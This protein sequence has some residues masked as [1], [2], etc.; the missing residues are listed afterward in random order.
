MNAKSIWARLSHVAAGIALS[1]VASV[2]LADDTDIY[3]NPGAGL[4]AGSE[5]M[6][7]FSL[8]YRPNL[9]STACNGNECDTLIA[10]G[11][12]APA[13]PYTFFD[14]LRAALRKAMEP[15]DGIRVGLM[16]NHENQNNCEGPNSGCSNGGYIAMGFQPFLTGDTNGAKA[17]FHAILE[18]MPTPQGNQSHAYQG[19]ELFFEFF[20]Y[21]TGGDIY[22]GHNGWT[23][24]ATNANDNLD[25]DGAAY[26]WDP[27]IEQGPRYRTPID[28]N[29]QC[30]NTY[31]VNFMFQVSNQE[32]DSDSAIEEPIGNGGFGSQQSDFDDVLAYLH[33]ADLA[34]GSYGSAPNVPGR[35]NVTSYFLIDDN[36][37]NNTTIGYA[38]A[39]G[40]G[41]PLE[42]TEDPDDLVRVLQEIFNQILSVSTTFVAASVPVNVFNRAEIVD[43]VFLA[44]FQVDENNRPGWTGNVKKLRLYDNGGAAFLVDSLDQPAVAPDGRIR[45]DALTH[46]TLAGS[47]PPADPNE[48]EVDGRD[49]RFVD[50]GGAGQRIPGYLGGSPGLINGVGTRQLFWDAGGNLAALDADVATAT[51]LQADL[52]AGN[53]AEAVELISFARGL[54]VDDLDSDGNTIDARPWIFSDPL[55]SRPLPLNYGVRGGYSTTNPAIFLAVASNDGF[56]RFIRNT[57]AAGGESGE[58]VWAFMPRSTMGAVRTLRANGAGTP[59]P[60]AVDGSPVA[61]VE[62]SNQNGTIEAGER[63]WLFFGLRRGG[64]AMYAL[65]VTDPESPQLMWS[66]EKSDPGFGE[67]GY[68]FSNPRIARLDWGNGMK[69]ALVFAGGYDMNKDTR[70]AVG[71]DDSEGNAIFVVDAENGNLIWKARGGSGGSTATIFEHSALV[72]SIPSTVALGDTDGD[73]LTDRVIVGDTGGNVWRADLHGNDTN[74]WTLSLVASLGRHAPGSVGKAD[75]RRFFHRPDIVQTSDAI[76]LFDAILIGAGDR[77]DPLDYGGVADNHFYMIK[78]RNVIPGS[79]T[80]TGIGHLDFGDVTNNCL[81]EGGACGVD[82]THGWRLDLEDTGEK[83][84]ATPVTID[85]TVFF[86]TYI[87]TG[88][89][90][91]GA[92][93]PSEGMGRLYAVSLQ[94]AA[95]VLNYDTSTDDPDGP[96]EGTTRSDRSTDLNSPGIP[97]EVVSVPPN[98][99]LRPDLQ[100]DEVDINTRWRTFWYIQEDSD[101]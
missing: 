99:I 14:V 2:C 35:Q 58:E 72:D 79:G 88:G 27:T 83:S 19:K 22:N 51:A 23:D 32:S 97:A 42:L 95:A 65:D 101:L 63:A 91:G 71:T 30:V 84:L 18:A 86:T 77:P 74:F 16:L 73:L 40:T 62:D 24:Y 44:L 98:K 48:G 7:M 5:P 3:L 92:C 96:D 52:G 54:D 59:H 75:D 15:L 6:V 45:F 20:R 49:G 10:E 34:N 87:P 39:G 90:A 8:D 28:A 56:M 31:S 11:Y 93:Q 4:P 68:T 69:P 55:H 78:D 37:I 12:M 25:V 100:V 38:H 64:K 29:A 82:L 26:D 94:N 46:W 66:I 85:G 76:G 33:D 81:Q 80:D 1:A 21:L 60:Y 9:G 13:G 41:T 67:L 50:R 17:Q 53:V 47:L 36:F 43:N 89:V 57:T 61:Y 70:G